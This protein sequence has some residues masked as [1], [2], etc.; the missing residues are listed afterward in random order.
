MEPHVPIIVA[1]RLRPLIPEEDPDEIWE[2]ASINVLR[3]PS[4]DF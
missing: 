2:V 4:T 3:A 1:A